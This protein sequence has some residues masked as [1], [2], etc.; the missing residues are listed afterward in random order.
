MLG[1][2]G[3]NGLSQ[4]PVKQEPPA[5]VDDRSAQ[6]LYED[7]N[8]YLGRRYQEFNK[9][10]LPYDPKVEAKTKQEQKDLAVKNAETLKG[11]KKLEP[12][13][14]YYLGLLHHLAGNADEAL[15]TM[16]VFLKDTVDGEQA[17]AARNV[18]VLYSVKKN[19][20]TA[21]GA[22]VETYRKHQPQNPEDLYK[23]EFL[24]ADAYLRAKDYPSLLKHAEGML[25]AARTFAT[26][27]KT[28]SFKRDDMLLKSTLLLS[29]GYEKTNQ[30][31]AAINRFEE[32][33]RAAIGF[34][35][36]NLYKQATIRLANAFPG[37]DLNKIYNDPA[38]RNASPP[39]IKATE[40]I[41]QKVVKLS[42]LRGQVVLLD[43]W[44]HWCGPCR[45]T[46]PKLIKWQE[47]YKDKGLVILG[48]TDYYGGAE[49]RKMTPAEE[50]AYLRQFKKNS[51]LSYGFVVADSKV[52]NLRYGVL[53]I[54]MSFLIDRR[55]VLRFIAADASDEELSRLAAMI[56]KLL[57]EP[58]ENKTETAA[59]PKN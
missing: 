43:F 23:M 5:T 38:M 31:E 59:S 58:A 47:Q 11:R 14:L 51:K 50:L 49:G 21:A 13:D 12:T 19:L 44:A 8:G 35:S 37:T 6:V 17:Q 32:L 57:E 7:A 41:D 45:R 54:P 29:E 4:A 55:G 3:V 39:E 48:L 56:P 28:E 27:R 46:F 53:T 52:N 26:E 18:V 2:F 10:K 36:G 20:I 16:N 9:Q 30:K 24:I 15:D 1:A 25:S 42:D 34:P 22:T 40:W 33:R